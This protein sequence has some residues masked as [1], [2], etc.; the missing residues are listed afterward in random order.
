M[1]KPFGWPT[2]EPTIS[3]R[4]HHWRDGTKCWEP[5]EQTGGFIVTDV[6]ASR[7]STGGRMPFIKAFRALGRALSFHV[8]KCD[9]RGVRLPKEPRRARASSEEVNGITV[10]CCRQG[11]K[12]LEQEVV[13][14]PSRGHATNAGLAPQSAP[15]PLAH[16]PEAA[17]PAI[18]FRMV[19]PVKASPRWIRGDMSP[20][21]TASGGPPRSRYI[22]DY[23]GGC[24]N[25][26]ARRRARSP[27]LHRSLRRSR[28]RPSRRRPSRRRP[29]RRR[30][31]RR[32][33]SLRRRS[34]RR[35]SH[36]RPWQPRG[37]RSSPR[38]A[39]LEAFNA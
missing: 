5:R 36:R 24:S 7:R 21:G 38:W 16:R 34:L 6:P 19:A 29:S 18:V 27:R 14:L 33:P 28:R 10:V 31:S 2:M 4:L 26:G 37:L 22:H 30:H 3:G 39:T 17:H 1:W 11:V 23:N 15:E 9:R 32:R 8:V 20:E 13:V 25:G 35:R 12:E